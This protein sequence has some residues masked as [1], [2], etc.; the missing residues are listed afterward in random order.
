MVNLKQKLHKIFI[1]LYVVNSILAIIILLL[2]LI[3]AV[4]FCNPGTDE[5]I[6]IPYISDICYF[7]K[8]RHVV[9]S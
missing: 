1:R 5:C 3:S 8:E 2:N 9:V 6:S 7:F 4:K